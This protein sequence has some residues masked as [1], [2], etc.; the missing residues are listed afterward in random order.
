MRLTATFIPSVMRTVPVVTLPVGALLL[1]AP[2]AAASGVAELGARD[3]GAQAPS[4]NMSTM[5]RKVIHLV[6]MRVLR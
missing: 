1:F 6:S 2:E 5:K 3:A 4:M